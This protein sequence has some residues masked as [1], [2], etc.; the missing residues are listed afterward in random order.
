[1]T[2]CGDLAMQ[3]DPRD[4]QDPHDPHNPLAYALAIARKGGRAAVLPADWQ[5][6]DL[7]SA[8]RLQHAVASLLGTVRGWK[9]SALS[10]AQ[11][12]GM[13][14]AGPVAGPLLDPWFLPSGASF[15]L[16]AFCRPPLLECEFAFVLGRDLP[17]REAPYER[18]EVEEA[19]VAMHPAIEVCDSRLASGSSTLQH[20]AD[21]LNNA[22][23]VLGPRRAD[24]RG[25]DYRTQPVTLRREG[26]GDDQGEGEL[27]ANGN[28]LPILEGDPV[29]A[30]V[31]MVNLQPHPWAGLRAGQV[32]TTGT[33]TAPVAVEASSGHASEAGYVADFGTLGRVHL[34]FTDIGTSGSRKDHS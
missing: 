6:P 12:R 14:V 28:A 25:V 9:V 3:A 33:C 4:P 19:I 16:A 2:I 34:R 15:A 21:G 32:I 30:V 27:L 26:A 20:L 18:A 17:Q 29:G 11:Q 13:Q 1:L 31:A 7:A 8:Y 5:V 10:A 24:W 23:F 22:A